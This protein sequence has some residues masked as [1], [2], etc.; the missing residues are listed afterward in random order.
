MP[1]NRPN[2]GGVGSLE[3]E[4]PPAP[5]TMPH[6]PETFV[7]LHNHTEFSLLDGASRINTMVARAAELGMPAL[8]LTDH[9]VMYGAIHFYKACQQA[10]IKPILGFEAYVAPRGRTDREVKVDRDPYHL[11]VLAASAEG[12]HNLMALCTI[13]QK[14]G[15][16]YKPR[17]DREALSRHSKGLIVLSGC[18]GGELAT[19]IAQGDVESAR[20]TVATYRDIFGAD[21]YLLEVQRHGIDLQ[22]QVNGTLAGFGREF[23]LRLVATNDLHYVHQADAEP[24]DVL[25]CLQTGATY[26]DPK[27][28]RFESRDFYLKTPQEM[29]EVF[30]DMPD[31][32]G[33]TLDIAAQVSVDLQLGHNLLPPFDVPAGITADSYLRH[34]A[35]E[36]LSWRYGE[37]PP[38]SVRER[39]DMELEVIRQTGFSSYILIVWDFYNF[40]RRNGIV[41]GPG[42]GSAAGS[43]VNYC[44]G[45]TNLDPVAH[46]LLFE[47]FLNKDRVSMP[48]IDCDFSVEGRERVIRYV[49]EKYGVD[50]VAQI[51]T[52]TTMAS[53][54]AIRD[55]G[56]VLEVPLKETDRLAKLVP[57]FQGRSK[58][59]DDALSEVPEFRVAYESGPQTGPDG[60]PYDPRRL[61][62][63]AR[64]LE[65]VSRNVSVHAAGVVIAPDELVRYSPLQWGP[66]SGTNGEDQA[67]QVIT[68]YDMKA[69]GEIGLLKMDFLGLQNLDIISTCLKLIAKTRGADLDLLQLGFDDPKTYALLADAD[70]HGVFQLEG[71]GMRRMLQE[72]RPQSF[73][74]IT[75]ANALFRPGPMQNIP[76]YIARKQGREKIEYL[77]PRLEPILRDSYG[78]MIYQ[79]QVMMAA[80]ELAGF[81]LSEAD[82]LRAAMGK[83]DKVKMAQQRQKFVEGCLGNGIETSMAEEL[84]DA[85]AKF[86]AYG[87]NRCVSGQTTVV[88]ALT[89]ERTTVAD[90]FARPRPFTIHGLGADGRLRPRQVTHVAFNGRKPVYE[91]VTSLGRR[92]RATSTHRFRI[93]EGWRRLGELAPGVQIATPGCLPTG[94]SESWPKHRLTALAGLLT[95]GDTRHP[96]TL[97]YHANDA[98]LIDD[99]AQAVCEFPDTTAY[100]RRHADGQFVVRVDPGHQARAGTGG[101]SGAYVWARSLGIT[102]R[103]P[104]EQR[105]PDAVFRLCDEDL[106]LLLGRLWLNGGS[107]ASDGGTVWFSTSSRDLARDVQL[108]LLR[109]GMVSGVREGGVDDRGPWRPGYDVCLIGEGSVD[110]FVRH[111]APHFAPT[112]VIATETRHMTA[113]ASTIG[114][115]ELVDAEAADILW[116]RIVSIQ[117]EGEEETYDLSVEV[118]HNFVA[119]GIVVHNSHAAAYAMISYQ[120]AYLKANYPVEYM[121]SLLTHMQG[122]ADKVAA[123]IV[124]TK[125]RGI[126]VLPPDVNE[127]RVDFSII[128]GRVRFGL[129]AIKNVGRGA[130]DQIVRER[131]S[132]GAFRSLD[133]FCERMAGV[134]DINARALDSL[135]RSGACDTFGERNHL[136]VT[137]DKARLRAEQARRDRESGQTSLFGL[138]QEVDQNALDYGLPPATPMSPEERLRHEKELLGVYLSDHP[139]NRI[140][141]ELATYTDTQVGELTADLVGREVRIGG[142]VRSWRRVVT[143]K[144]QIMAY[145]EVEDLTGVV[146]A[147]FFPRAY[148]DFRKAMELPDAVVI[149]HGKLDVARSGG[150]VRT[151]VVSAD[152]EDLAVGEDEPEAVTLIAEA[153]WDWEHRHD[154]DQ[155]ERR[156][157][158]HIDVPERGPEVVDELLTLLSRHPGTDDVFIHFRLQGNQV[159]VQV[160]ERFRVVAGQA[161]K[162]D[163]DAHFEREVTRLDSVRPRAQSNS[164]GSRQGR[165]G[166]GRANGR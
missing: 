67:R 164:N 11:T 19:K 128:D 150:A 10:C 117:P 102:G 94:A 75:A 139:L 120:T 29:A 52:F 3:S 122:N 77:H 24:H 107:M 92:I 88:H 18:L 40:A 155:L 44:L 65:G 69:V 14:E 95:D 34:K 124:D 118:D 60:R 41:T 57:V 64:S 58:S 76:A 54:A 123:A 142:L 49:T 165:N 59:L 16:Y 8:A 161:L 15:L 149:I 27:R 147:T 37:T 45:I 82:I 63:V 23:G 126:D 20:E 115:R 78:V 135:V 89:G 87:F 148:D 74:D 108:M 90:L 2:H 151:A 12:Y 93:G 96:T 131:D 109:L 91:L 35:E 140:E 166:N 153:V 22:N 125:K 157:I 47:R 55:V 144:G 85:I 70:T 62:D 51:I 162:D 97:H 81:T 134:Q 32:L 143:R 110:N 56:R 30:A 84:F 113:A 145:A 5:T 53:K 132:N 154:C 158:V 9:G 61:I 129:A 159:T 39:L 98:L 79:E 152:E 6:A 138:V 66:R 99:F 104:A 100:V 156:R 1:G 137:L 141:Q 73:A 105:V 28:W 7:H 112:N 86:A 121:T 101:P 136:L 72:M 13:G 21:R 103:S 36:G 114:R 25:L 38:E 31:A 80:R 71:S 127:S 106:R 42:R 17:I 68:Q 160:G 4:G 163:L 83:K 33:A 119:D 130:V 26:D 43:L 133:D 48:D 111:V 146:E 50:R 116:D 46:G